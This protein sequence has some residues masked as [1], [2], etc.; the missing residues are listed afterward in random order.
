MINFLSL[1]I[2]KNKIIINDKNSNFFIL[3]FNYYFLT[4]LHFLFIIL[5]IIIKMKPKKSYIKNYL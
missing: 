3:N 5:K 4:L 2:I 1:K